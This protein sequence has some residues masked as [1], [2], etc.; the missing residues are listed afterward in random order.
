M[1]GKR[2][3]GCGTC[4]RRKVKCDQGR[5]TCRRCSLVG[6]DCLGY[7]R[8]LQWV[9]AMHITGKT[10][11]TT[12]RSTSSQ[13][14]ISSSQTGSSRY[15]RMPGLG[16]APLSMR[17][18]SAYNDDVYCGF[19][20]DKYFS[21]GNWNEELEH[22]KGW[23]WFALQSPSE[24][25]VSSYACRSLV[26]AFFANVTRTETLRRDAFCSHR[27]A[28]AALKLATEQEIT[29]DVLSAIVLLALYE[30]CFH[31]M[32]SAWQVRYSDSKR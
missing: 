32:Q 13:S 19:F 1:V 21:F 24:N 17:L 14:T 4:I 9:T 26:T 3:Q 23:I 28:L 15:R 7:E 11:R 29:F 20:L 18:P 31:T 30:A 8:P 12:R 6:F 22:N 25:P 16:T 2:S 27:D 5:P 10:S